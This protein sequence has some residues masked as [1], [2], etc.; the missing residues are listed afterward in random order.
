MD[1]SVQRRFCRQEVGAHP[2]TCPT[3]PSGTGTTT[4]AF[5]GDSLAGPAQQGRLR[6]TS[7]ARSPFRSYLHRG[8]RRRPAIRSCL[9]PFPTGSRRVDAG[10]R[11]TITSK[12]PVHTAVM[13]V[14]TMIVTLPGGQAP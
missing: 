4:S 6:T 12:G 8:P 13:V 3:C 7:G 1:T 11:A 9:F 14:Q 10:V 2:I 5:L